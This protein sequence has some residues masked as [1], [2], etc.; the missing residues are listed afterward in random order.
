MGRSLPLYL[1]AIHVS[2]RPKNKRVYSSYSYIIINNVENAGI[3][4]ILGA[5]KSLHNPK[6][7]WHVASYNTW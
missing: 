7:A 1:L 2:L 4:K 3:A 6:N 5:H